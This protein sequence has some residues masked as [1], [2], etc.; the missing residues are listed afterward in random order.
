MRAGLH[1]RLDARKQFVL[2]VGVLEDRFDDDVGAGHTVAGARPARHARH[3]LAGLAGILE[4][5]LEQPRAHASSAGSMN[6]ELAILQRDVEPALR[7]PGGDVAAHDTG[8]DHVHAL[9]ASRRLLPPRLLSRSCS[10]NTRTRLREVSP[11]NRWAMEC[12]SASKARSPCA[13]YFDHKS[14]IA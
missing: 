8:A 14:M 9:A 2:G 13:P 4:P 11:T 12:A 3:E 10:M 5:F 1:A 7:A 6:F